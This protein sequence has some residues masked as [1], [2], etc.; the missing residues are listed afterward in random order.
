MTDQGR[1]IGVIKQ[2]QWT[3]G[4]PI[5]GVLWAIGAIFDRVWFAVD[6]SVPGWDQA[7]YLTGAM[8]YWQALQQPELFSG[9]WWTQ[10]WMLSSK[11]PPLVYISTTPFIAL[12][13]AGEEQST[14]V[15]LFY[16]AILLGSVYGL[17][18]RLFNVQTGLWAAGLCLLMPGLYV[19][20]LDYLIDYPLVAIVTLTFFCLTLWAT[21]KKSD[22]VI[23]P[24][25]NP[26][27]VQSISQSVAIAQT[28]SIPRFQQSVLRSWGYSIAFGVSLGLAFLVKQPAVFFLLVPILWLGITVLRQRQWRRLLQLV[29]ALIVGF[30]ICLPWYRTNWL[31]IITA[32]KRATID[33]AI[34]EG[35][36][37]L[38]DPQSWLYYLKALPELISIP[39][40][41][42]G[43]VGL[44]L[45][46][47][48]SIVQQEWT[49][50][51]GRWTRSVDYGGLRKR[52]YRRDVYQAW[53]RSINWLLIFLIGSYLLS[54]LN[55]NKDDRYIT[56]L[57]PVFAVLLA[58]GLLLF[59][60]RLR[61]FRWGAIG[62]SMLLMI[63]NTIP[64]QFAPKFLLGD[65][66]RNAVLAS[67]WHQSDVISSVIETEPYLRTTIG[68]LPSLIEFN[69]HNLNYAGVLRNFQV[70]GRQLGTRIEQTQQDARSLDWYVTKSGNGGAIRR[71]DAYAAL[72]DAI[73][74]NPDFNLHRSWLAP[75]NSQINLYKRK[76]PPVQVEPSASVGT[77]PSRVKLE[78]LRIPNRVA[79]GKPTP[80]VYR[81]SGS[82]KQIRSGIV[83]LSWNR[84]ASLDSI[85]TE[86]QRAEGNVW[87]HDHAIALGNLHASAADDQAQF[88]V[89]ERLAM[90]PPIEAQ[91]VYTLYARYLNRETGET[92]DIAVPDTTL[93]VAPDAAA[94]AAP[95][96][97]F[98]TQ[99]RS[100]A[101]TMPQGLKALDRIF[102]EVGKLNQYDPVQDY[103]T[104]FRQALEYRFKQDANN[105][106]FGY[107]LALANVLKR[108]VQPAI[109]TLDRVVQLDGKNP[110]AYAYL[111]FVN[112]YDFR[113]G[114][115]QS[116]INAALALAPN[117]SELHIL[118]AVAGLMQ[119]N[120][121]QA[122]QEY[123]KFK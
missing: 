2:Q 44:A 69:Q 39:I 29:V 38:S 24:L 20:R 73:A 40:L 14:L 27:T 46:W 77:I 89:T 117:Q 97:D 16:S 76:I 30:F 74:K 35:E 106:E 23:K 65:H 34:A 47:K 90:L 58:Q 31:I 64:I 112:L 75:D 95:E 116:A 9:A 115:A 33:S 26:I 85:A 70:Y 57:L 22:A 111:A 61:W 59:P 79:P 7:E 80:I 96:L 92:Y 4:L 48:R 36:P 25:P 99:L 83:L 101:A 62:L 13:G 71:L 88:D 114:A 8:N 63:A 49:Q 123:Q 6:R 50:I 119:G 53:G 10:F 21:E 3:K 41:L 78:Q 18:V 113:S 68:V 118:K 51:A 105:V 87:Y 12:F 120:I 84:T 109:D 72:T 17:G 81:W 86:K 15:N 121:M 52:G 54:S 102:A 42:V 1:W 98:V 108:R 37:P 19:I 100:L 110:N 28:F 43:L 103:V 45:Y 91:G 122:W 11:M 66:H 104:Q 55:V 67:S 82:W 60:D 93:I 94:S 56:P 5:V 107:G 32:G